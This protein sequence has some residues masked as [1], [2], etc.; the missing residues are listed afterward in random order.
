MPRTIESPAK[1]KCDNGAGTLL[2]RFGWEVFNHPPYSPDLAPSD[3]H[4]FPHMKNWL[5]GQYFHTDDELQIT[6][7]S[8]LKAQAAAFYHEND[9][10]QITVNSWLKA[11]AAAFYHESIGK[12]IPRYEK[13]LHRTGDYVEK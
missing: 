6:V 8:W 12:L 1:S 5:G 3:F 2:R 4:L 11:Q 10:L 13:C 9:E 7:N